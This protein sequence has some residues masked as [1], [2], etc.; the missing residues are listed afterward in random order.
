MSLKLTLRIDPVLIQEAKD[1]A[2]Q[3][4]RSVSQI[5]GDYFALLGSTKKK[6]VAIAL[7]PI[8]KSLKG[9]LKSSALSKRDYQ[10]YLEKKY[11]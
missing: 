9:V 8:T 3:H 6:L 4:K 1:Y 10:H 11:L 7:P 2:A 5:V